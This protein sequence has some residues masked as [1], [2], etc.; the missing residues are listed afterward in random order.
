MHFILLSAPQ[1]NL[2][3]CPFQLVGW[4]IVLVEMAAN[5][6]FCE[7][8]RYHILKFSFSIQENFEISIIYRKT[9]Y[10]KIGT[11]KVFFWS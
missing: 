6:T 1:Q 10:G 11:W 8:Y 7:V 4:F 9:I 2:F 5:G 3:H